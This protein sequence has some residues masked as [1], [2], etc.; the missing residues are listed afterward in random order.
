MADTEKT[1]NEFAYIVSHDLGAPLRAM[2]AFSQLLA[3][4]DSDALGET[5]RLYLSMIIDNGEKAQK[6][7]QGLLE[8]SR[9]HTHAAPSAPADM[10]ALWRFCEAEAA[11]KASGATIQARELP[12]VHA[13]SAQLQRVLAI[14]LDNAL[15]YHA[16]RDAPRVE[17]SAR[18]EE[19]E[20]VVTV[21]DHGIGIAP[22][23]HETVFLPFKRL[24]AEEEFPSI[25]MGLSIARR[26]VERHGGRIWA[27]SAPGGGA[28]FHFTLP[29]AEDA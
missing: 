1:F 3:A 21:R 10:Q 15:T 20:W 24:H 17:V 28:A 11:Q 16:P 29:M 27:E 8:Y 12:V 18:A 25:G 4:C 23:F 26:I 5:E 7:L 19:G 13:D 2:I 9:T 22:K 14:L 6:M